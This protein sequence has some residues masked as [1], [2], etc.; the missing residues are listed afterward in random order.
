[1]SETAKS[2]RKIEEII[3][4]QFKRGFYKEYLKN[5]C[6]EDEQCEIKENLHPLENCIAKIY[7]KDDFVYHITNKRIIRYKNN[8]EEVITYEELDS[9]SWYLV[10]Y[11][12]K[13]EG[14]EQ[15]I[16]MKTKYSDSLIFKRKD[17]SE[18]QISNLG[19]AVTPLYNSI[20]WY[21]RIYDEDPRHWF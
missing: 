4:M 17:G 19:S 12:P 9:V 8:I 5:A 11:S 14:Y 13:N 20:A 1:M 6:F 18:I 3:S 21:K 10:R 2:K 15:I 16:D 7:S